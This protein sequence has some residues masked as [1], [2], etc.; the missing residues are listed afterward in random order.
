LAR[1]CDGRK[2]QMGITS[3]M[4]TMTLSQ[5]HFRHTSLQDVILQHHEAWQSILQNIIDF[6]TPRLHNYGGYGNPVTTIPIGTPP[7]SYL[8]PEHPLH[9]PSLPD[10]SQS[11]TC[12][13]HPV[14][15]LPDN[16][17]SSTCSELPVPDLPCVPN[18]Q[19]PCPEHPSHK[20]SD[21]NPSDHHRV[22]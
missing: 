9:L 11:S 7:S 6:P 19:S 20:S 2:R 12:S 5:L 4:E 3:L 22:C 21:A 13:E 18:P 17:Q 14:P 10:N 8:T 1:E 16:S 15:D